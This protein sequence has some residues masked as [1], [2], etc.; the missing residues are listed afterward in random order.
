MIGL[1]LGCDSS[2]LANTRKEFEEL[3][4]SKKLPQWISTEGEVVYHQDIDTSKAFCDIQGHHCL[5]VS[6]WFSYKDNVNDTTSLFKDLCQQGEAALKNITGGIF[7]ALFA[8]KEHYFVFNDPMGLSNH[9]Y[10]T[11]END[12]RIAPSITVFERSDLKLDVNDKLMGFLMKRG[13]L[14]GNF[15]K[16][17]QV[18]RLSP[19]CIL[20]KDG[21]SKTYFSALYTNTLPMEQ[22][23]N[24][25]TTIINKFPKEKRQLP[26]TGGLDSRLMLCAAE[27]NFGYCYGPADSADRP[28]ARQF[29]QEFQEFIEFEFGS[30][31]KNGNEISIYEELCETPA[32]MIKAEFLASYRYAHTQ[33]KSAN[34][35]F[36]GFLGGSLQRGAWLHLGG[37]LGELYR[38]FPYLYTIRPITART[39]LKRRYKNLTSEEF[40]LFFENFVEKTEHVDLDDYAKVTY[41]EFLWGRGARF[42]NNGALIINGQFGQ[43][44]PMFS[45]PIVFNSLISQDFRKTIRYQTVC[46]IWGSVDEK[47]KRVKF[48]NGYKI[49]TPNVIKPKISL[50]WRLLS[51][52]VPG[53]GNYGNS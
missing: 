34:I 40:E 33:C 25:F 19:G 48:E 52:Y 13:H 17:N 12:L 43:I 2:A 24:R 36:D 32:Q 37:I 9:F 21:C 35:T 1:Y 7:I 14:F 31:N 38:F 20:Y 27:F 49:S 45:D 22:I 23:L 29:S 5:V 6:G 39:L 26:I 51:R 15:T 46:N 44:V 4:D 8:S 18:K 47:F 42:I 3:H 16:Y 28:I 30:T 10:T 53:F 50:I 11:H 41:Y